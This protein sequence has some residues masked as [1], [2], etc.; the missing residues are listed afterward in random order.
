MNNDNIRSIYLKK[1]QELDLEYVNAASM[2]VYDKLKSIEEFVCS[3]HVLIYV[4]Y[5]N[6]IQ[7]QN[8]IK[9]LLDNGKCV[10]VPK[11]LEKGIMDFYRINS[12]DDLIEG[13]KGI[14]EPDTNKCKRYNY[15]DESV[16]ICPGVVFDENGN[17][18]GF[19]GGYY[20]RYLA[21]NKLFAIGLAHDIQVVKEIK[22]VKNTD[23][24]MNVLVT[25]KE[26]RRWDI[27]KR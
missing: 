12:F 10:Y 2:K 25:P 14:V 7:T 1:R 27:L 11:V 9:E 5:K 24:P 22:D 17:R 21:K 15:V 8:I 3:K 13:F 6:E 18:I 26:V 16:I 23:I 4:S 20:D 19:G